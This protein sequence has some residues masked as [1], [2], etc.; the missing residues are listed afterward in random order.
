MTTY[1]VSA[2][3]FGFLR[4]WRAWTIV[5]PVVIVNA[6]VQALLIWPDPTPTLNT[7][8]IVI[9]VLS[10]LAFVLS[11]GLVASASLH[12]ADGRTDWHAALRTLRAHGLRFLIWGALLA[13]VVIIGLA[14]YTL[15]GLVIVALTPFV[16]LAALDGRRNPLGTNLRVIGRRFWRWLFTTLITGAILLLAPVAGDLTSFFVRGS[17]A[18]FG[19]W[20]VTGAVIAWFTVTWAL[21]YRSALAPEST[22]PAA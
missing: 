18:A 10:G 15:P 11:Y 17:L 5:V 20:L 1:R 9:A 3:A 4:M 8:A 21:I 14:A 7:L 2:L 16:L 6:A 12:V 19:I 22:A 13:I